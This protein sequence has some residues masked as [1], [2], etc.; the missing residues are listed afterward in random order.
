MKTAPAF[1]FYWSDFIHGTADMTPAEVGGYI[2]LLC[3]QWDHGYIPDDD[4]KLAAITH[5]DEIAVASIRLKF[6]YCDDGCLRNA[7]LEHVRSEQIRFRENQALK[8]KKRWQNSRGYAKPHAAA[9]ATAKPR[10]KPRKSRNDALYL[11]S[12][13]EEESRERERDEIA[14]EIYMRYPRKIGKAKGIEAIMTALKTVPQ[15]KI[16]RALDAS[17]R[18]WELEG[19]DRQFIPYPATWIHGNPWDDELS[20]PAEIESQRQYESAAQENRQLEMAEAERQAQRRQKF[21]EGLQ[22]IEEIEQQ[23]QEFALQ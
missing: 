14:E 2:R 13:K 5:C 17:I 18:L 22:E 6:G 10:H 19:R 3:Y 23:E 1:Q 7:K 16:L 15:E 8:G 4:R 9:N 20:S 21:I 11:S 12:S